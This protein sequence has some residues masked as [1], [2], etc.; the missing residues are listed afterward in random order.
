MRVHRDRIRD[1]I[2]GEL[3]ATEITVD[4]TE[5]ERQ[6]TTLVWESCPEK[7]RAIKIIY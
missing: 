4:K 2:S 5:K 1:L 3:G 6:T 7:A